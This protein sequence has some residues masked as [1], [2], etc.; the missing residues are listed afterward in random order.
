MESVFEVFE[1]QKELEAL[2]PGQEFLFELAPNATTNR[3]S[4]N[5]IRNGVVE[6]LQAFIKTRWQ[7]GSIPNR[8]QYERLMELADDVLVKMQNLDG[9][10]SFGFARKRGT[11]VRGFFIEDRYI[12]KKL[13]WQGYVGLPDWFQGFD[14]YRQGARFTVSRKSGK[15]VTTFYDPD[16]ISIKSHKPRGGLRNI[17]LNSLDKKMDEWLTK[18]NPNVL[19]KKNIKIKRTAGPRTEEVHLILLGDEDESQFKD[20]I[21][22]IAKLAKDKRFTIKLFQYIEATDTFIPLL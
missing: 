13:Q 11:W 18:M 6:D 20:K 2:Y 8:K 14:A 1:L 12:E 22:G 21:Q 9:A 7:S 5:V 4:V 17:D 15:Y 10:R 16:L 3:L 19:E